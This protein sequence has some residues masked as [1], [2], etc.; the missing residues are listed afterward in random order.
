[1]FGANRF[2]H[3]TAELY[4]TGG[5]VARTPWRVNLLTIGGS[6]AMEVPRLYFLFRA[7]IC[8]IFEGKYFTFTFPFA[9]ASRHM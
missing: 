5:E 9:L 7:Y 3:V 4:G 1:M 8:F 6:S 2:A